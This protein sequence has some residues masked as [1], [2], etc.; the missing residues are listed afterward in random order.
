MKRNKQPTVSVPAITAPGT[1][2]FIMTP[3][4]DLLE[5]I[6]PSLALPRMRPE[7]RESQSDALVQSRQ[8][9]VA[10]YGKEREGARDVRRA[11]RSDQE[12]RAGKGPA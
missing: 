4:A 5:N 9:G 8:F 12:M 11:S 3:D 7:F 10:F 1:G 6:F 2:T